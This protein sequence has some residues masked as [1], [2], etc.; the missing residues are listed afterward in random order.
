MFCALCC[1]VQ[2]S[3]IISKKNSSILKAGLLTEA[4]IILFLGGFERILI[5][6]T[7]T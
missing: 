7:G 6:T 1:P 4:T 2:F 3:I 5:L